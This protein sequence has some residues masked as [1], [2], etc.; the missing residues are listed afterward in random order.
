MIVLSLFLAPK[1]QV[2]SKKK[3]TK[4]KAQKCFNIFQNIRF[5]IKKKEKEPKRKKKYI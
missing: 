3:R 5:V 1:K 2:F 4:K